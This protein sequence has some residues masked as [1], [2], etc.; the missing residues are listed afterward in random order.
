MTARAQE[1]SGDWLRGVEFNEFSVYSLPSSA[2]FFKAAF[3]SWSLNQK[4]KDEDSSH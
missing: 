2:S 4:Q 1:N 3:V